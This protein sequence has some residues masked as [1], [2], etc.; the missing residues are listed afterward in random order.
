MA[1]GVG[2]WQNVYNFPHSS[3]LE[4]DNWEH[5]EDVEKDGLKSTCRLRQRFVIRQEENVAIAARSG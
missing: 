2:L 4:V 1:P 3:I 5:V